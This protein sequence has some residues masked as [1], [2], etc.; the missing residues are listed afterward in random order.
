MSAE[1]Q[2]ILNQLYLDEDYRKNFF[3]NP[4]LFYSQINFQDSNTLNFLK[5]LNQEQV[6]FFSKGLYSKRI[7]SASA[8]IPCTVKL[9]KE[10]HKLFFKNFSKI[11]QPAGIHKHHTDALEYCF[12]IEK[13]KKGSLFFRT[14][15]KFE[16]D[17]LKNFLDP[18][19][20]RVRF[21]FFNPLR[22][23]KSL[24]L[25]ASASESYTPVLIIWKD[26]M[27]KTSFSFR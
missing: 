10:E 19:K 15:L 21:Y 4:V 1:I 25:S 22:F 12:F 18:V 23:R 3:D 13:N 2:N 20:F 24:H 17:Q 9:L 8:L 5:S 7:H 16:M 14:V 27:I 6:E 11:F 26:G